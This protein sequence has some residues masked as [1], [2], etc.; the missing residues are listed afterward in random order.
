MK[1]EESMADEI[2]RLREENEKLRIN[3][4]PLLMAAVTER[5]EVW[6]PLLEAAKWDHEKLHE[7]ADMPYVLNGVSCKGCAIIATCEKE[8]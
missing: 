4:G 6:L 5:A 3:E 2:Q 8:R 1:A 7:V